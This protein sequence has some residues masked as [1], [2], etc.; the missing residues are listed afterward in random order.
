MPNP[1]LLVRALAAIDPSVTSLDEFRAYSS[2]QSRSVAAG[3]LEYLAAAGIGRMSGG[4]S[5]SFSAADRIAAAMLCIRN[6]CDIREVSTRI[7]WRDFEQLASEALKSFG[8]HTRTNVLFVKP[9]MEIDVVGVRSFLA[10]AIDCKHW[11]RSNRSSIS[12]YSRKQAARTGR[13]V[14]TDPLVR[15][16][17][18]LILTLHA[19]SVKFVDRI[20]IVPVAQFRSFLE[21]MQAYLP[22]ICIV[23]RD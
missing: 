22:E 18:P 16:A 11:K 12:Q 2:I 8:Y 5:I 13:L 19:E 21:D 20:P 10:L 1:E 15:Q 7:S 17:I 9:R 3:M 6:G 23:G 14:Q 4:R